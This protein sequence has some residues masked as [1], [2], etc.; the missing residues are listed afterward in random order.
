MPGLQDLRGQ[1][2]GSCQAYGGGGG[3][4]NVDFNL[5]GNTWSWGDFRLDQAVAKGSCHSEEGVHIEEFCLRA[6][7]APTAKHAH[8][9]AISPE[10]TSFYGEIQPC[11]GLWANVPSADAGV[12]GQS[13]WPRFSN[14]PWLYQWLLATGACPHSAYR[15]AT[16]ANF[17]A[18]PDHL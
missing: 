2:S 11:T 15:A 6:G 13:S 12:T 1:W 7:D 8:D 9:N 14:Q 16:Q 4:T 17:E 10:Q 18:P 3:A 5:R